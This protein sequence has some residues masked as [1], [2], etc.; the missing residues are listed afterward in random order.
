MNDQSVKP[1]AASL[2]LVRRFAAPRERVFDAL[3]SPGALR[4]W[5]GP[6]GCHCPDPQ[7][8]LQVGGAYRLDIENSEGG[9]NNLHGRY[10]EVSP[11]HR[12][13]FTW[14]WDEGAYAGVETTVT[15]DLAERDG[16]TEL[17]LTHG[18]FTSQEMCDDHDRGWSSSV[19]CLRDIV[20]EGD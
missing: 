8:D 13:A 20:E 18:G 4:V 12:L 11:P 10:L 5:W 6:E 7:V 2:T 15:I 17:T 1:A 19:D 3:T 16:G 9:R 14:T